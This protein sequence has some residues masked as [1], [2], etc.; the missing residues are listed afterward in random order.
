MALPDGFNADP[1]YTEANEEHGRNDQI[2]SRD[3]SKL[4]EARGDRKEPAAQREVIGCSIPIQFD[5][6]AIF[7]D[8]NFVK[9]K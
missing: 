7:I 6:K 5:L 3:C 8:S 1:G 4:Q 2:D 9:V